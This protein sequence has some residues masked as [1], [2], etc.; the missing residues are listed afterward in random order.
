MTVWLP[1]IQSLRTPTSA[2]VASL[3][4]PQIAVDDDPPFDRR[5]LSPSPE[6]ATERLSVARKRHVVPGERSRDGRGGP[7]RDIGRAL[8]AGCVERMDAA[9]AVAFE[10]HPG[11]LARQIAEDDPIA[12]ILQ[13]LAGG[14]RLQ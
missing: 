1:I 10:R 5:E 8:A 11:W 7:G 12:R 4:E 9:G 13:D 6:V 2:D 3:R 14:N